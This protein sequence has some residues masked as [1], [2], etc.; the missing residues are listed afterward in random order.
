MPQ[1]PRQARS[2]SAS[3]RARP[4]DRSGLA[5]GALAHADPS[6]DSRARLTQTSRIK[7]ARVVPNIIPTRGSPPGSRRPDHSAFRMLE[8]RHPRLAGR[9]ATPC[10]YPP[11]KGPPQDASLGSTEACPKQPDQG[12]SCCILADSVRTGS[13]DIPS[14]LRKRADSHVEAELNDVAVLHDVVLALHAH[15]APRLRLGHRSGGDQVVVRDDLGLD[16]APL[17]VSV[18]HAGGF[19]RR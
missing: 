5:R 4:R 11:P 12:P 16:E 14:E 10:V 9:M 3:H 15:Q 2:V 13:H 1:S 6:R 7:G 8:A 18:D 19:R 17:E